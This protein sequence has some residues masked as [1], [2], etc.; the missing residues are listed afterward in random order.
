[1]GRLAWGSRGETR[2]VLVSTGCNEVPK[3]Q[4]G[5]YWAS[6]PKPF[7]D[8]ERGSDSNVDLKRDMVEE[9]LKKA[10]PGA[11]AAARDFL[12]AMIAEENQPQVKHLIKDGAGCGAAPS[13]ECAS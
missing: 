2:H 7:R 6:D 10:G 8:L 4:G 5:L 13:E 3:A 9:A 12:L 1:M 11:S